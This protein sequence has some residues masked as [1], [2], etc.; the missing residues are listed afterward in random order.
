MWTDWSRT[1]S[2]RWAV[3]GFLIGAAA[4][5]IALWVNHRRAALTHPEWV[6]LLWRRLVAGVAAGNTCEAQTFPRRV[7]FLFFFLKQTRRQRFRARTCVCELFWPLALVPAVLWDGGKLRH[8]AVAVQV[9]CGPPGH[10]PLQLPV[11]GL[12]ALGRG[13]VRQAAGDPLAP[14]LQLRVGNLK[15]ETD[16]S[17]SWKAPPS[18]ETGQEDTTETRSAALKRH[19]CNL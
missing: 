9:L 5:L 10:D 15:P 7:G 16:L 18:A 14:P 2:E 4:Q 13:V 17:F 6:D 19:T 11:V 3:K 1:E 12:A 8:A